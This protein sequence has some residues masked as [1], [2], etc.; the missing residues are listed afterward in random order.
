MAIKN[1]LSVDVED[2]FQAEA[3]AAHS[4]RGGWETME[5]RVV[6]N[7][8]RVL[9]LLGGHNA[10]ATYFILNK[11]LAYC[12]RSASGFDAISTVKKP[13]WARFLDNSLRRDMYH[14]FAW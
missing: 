3:I 1:G 13:G 8:P 6:E 7:T 9:D 2:Y 4:G 12:A 5:S 14:C 11:V 10:R